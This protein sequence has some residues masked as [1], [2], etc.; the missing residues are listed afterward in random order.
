VLGK[1]ALIDAP[2]VLIAIATLGILLRVRRVPEP[3]VV[4]AAGVVGVTIRAIR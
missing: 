3:I 2:T 1:R 4:V